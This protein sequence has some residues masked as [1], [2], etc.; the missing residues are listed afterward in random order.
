MSLQISAVDSIGD[1]ICRVEMGSELKEL[2]RIISSQ[3]GRGDTH[4]VASDLL[5]RLE[6][7]I[8]EIGKPRKWDFREILSGQKQKPPSPIQIMIKSH[9]FWLIELSCSFIPVQEHSIIW[10]RFVARL[11]IPHLS[12]QPQVYDLYPLEI[13]DEVEQNKKIGIGLDFKF[14]NVVEG[15]LGNYLAEIKF[16]K[17]EPK[18]VAALGERRASPTW[19]FS[20][21]QTSDVRGYKLMYLVVQ[22]PRS[23]TS[24]DFEFGLFAKIQ[25]KWG[26]FPVTRKKVLA[27]SEHIAV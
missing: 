13:Y 12:E 14:A 16:T 17:L 8:I 27:G 7:D 6:G 15:T 24:L 21:T 5:K 20:S 9:S 25:T 2:E 11:N 26:L 22:M 23:A 3:R 4:P 10:A 1:P 19:N 18:V